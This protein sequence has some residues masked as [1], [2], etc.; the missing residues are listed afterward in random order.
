ML[1]F[2]DHRLRGRRDGG[3]L[4]ATVLRHAFGCA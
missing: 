2:D 4:G 3:D 1:I